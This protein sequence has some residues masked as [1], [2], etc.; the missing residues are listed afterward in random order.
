MSHER[1]D[2]IQENLRRVERPEIS[3]VFADNCE[4]THFDGRVLRLEFVVNRWD[5]PNGDGIRTGEKHVICRLILT[6]EGAR[7]LH[8]RLA[9]IA[10]GVIASQ[11]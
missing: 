7:E 11:A 9:V 5:E 2:A 3:E 4:R 1:P 6:A 10:Q 8:E